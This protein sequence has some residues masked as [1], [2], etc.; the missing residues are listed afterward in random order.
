M[1]LSP[2]GHYLCAHCGEPRLFLTRD[3]LCAHCRAE[4]CPPA[5]RATIDE[6]GMPA[7]AVYSFIS[8][9][10][11]PAG[12]FN[13]P[14]KTD[15]EKYAV[16]WFG[17]IISY[18]APPQWPFMTMREPLRE[19]DAV[20]QLWRARVYLRECGAYAEYLWDPERGERWRYEDTH[21]L[22]DHGRGMTALMRGRRLLFR[23]LHPGG[24]N[25]G[26]TR[27]TRA[28]FY[29]ETHI[30][31]RTLRERAG[32]D[33]ELPSDIELYTELGI[34]AATFYRY[35]KDWGDPRDDAPER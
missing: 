1:P 10:D 7:E 19:G 8:S 13:F 4:L 18:H 31:W 33:A 35:L 27:M 34:S 5:I 20:I 2:N 11:A 29:R 3:R 9:D 14:E 24:R 12:R 23:A 21:L 6:L 16:T 26:S 22:P 17:R 32:E 15:R 28:V 25:V 30:A